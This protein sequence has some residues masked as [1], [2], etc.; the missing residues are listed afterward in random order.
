[1]LLYFANDLT[2][3]NHWRVSGTQYQRTSEDWLKN[4]DA[5]REQVLPI[6]A[7]TYGESHVRQWWVYWRVFFMSCAEL[8]GY[9]N[10]EEWIVSHYL[11]QKR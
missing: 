7:K 2:I 4:M 6:L 9:R 11:F 3:E 10:G 1:L 8:W 5:H